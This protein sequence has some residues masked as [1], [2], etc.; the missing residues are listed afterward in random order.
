MIP[1]LRWCSL[2]A[3]GLFGLAGC[4]ATPD[5]EVEERAADIRLYK[6]SELSGTRYEVV[7][8]IWV[9]SW[10]T[11]FWAPASPDRDAALASLRNEAARLNA[12]GLVNVVCLDQ[13]PSVGSSSPQPSFL[14]YGSAIRVRGSAG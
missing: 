10:R 9:D 11:A 2:F 14:C 6:L 7:S 5:K 13:G 8:H 4:A 12:N 3:A 1:S